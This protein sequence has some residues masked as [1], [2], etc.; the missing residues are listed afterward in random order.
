MEE[1]VVLALPLLVV[2]P[3]LQLGNGRVKDGRMVILV[4]CLLFPSVLIGG[5]AR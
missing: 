3:A 4:F 2:H 5:N 1:V